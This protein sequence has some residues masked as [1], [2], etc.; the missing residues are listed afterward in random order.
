MAF[1]PI[2]GLVNFPPR[3]SNGT[4][5]V[6]ALQSWTLRYINCFCGSSLFALG[7]TLDLLQVFTESQESSGWKRPVS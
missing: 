4:S 2:M 7:F 6:T 3:N 1:G 5:F